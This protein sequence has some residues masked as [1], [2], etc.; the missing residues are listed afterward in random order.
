[1][2]L[3]LLTC[4]LLY[5]FFPLAEQ[6]ILGEWWYSLGPKEK[7]EYS[8]LANQV[9]EAHFKRHPDWKWC[10]RGG[11]NDKI[12]P[13]GLPLESSPGG[14][15][16]GI[17]LKEE[18][19]PPG[20]GNVVQSPSSSTDG[21]KSNVSKVAAKKVK[22]SSVSKD[23][24]SVGSAKSTDSNEG[25]ST[26]N[27]QDRVGGDQDRV[28][29]DQDSDS[30]FEEE[31]VIDL[32]RRDSM[33][34]DGEDSSQ[35]GTNCDHNTD[36]SNVEMN[37]LTSGHKSCLDT[38]SSTLGAKSSYVAREG[39]SIGGLSVTFNLQEPCSRSISSPGSSNQGGINSSKINSPKI[40]SSKINSSKINSSNSSGSSFITF[41]NMVRTPPPPACVT[42]SSHSPI[43]SLRSPV[44]MSQA[45][46]P[47][48]GTKSGIMK[49][50][51]HGYQDAERSGNQG[52]S[53]HQPQFYTTVMNLKSG[54]LS[55]RSPP[56]TI[57]PSVKIDAP[58]ESSSVTVPSSSG[59][60]FVLAPTPAQLGIIRNKKNQLPR[61]SSPTDLPTIV[62]SSTTSSQS[63]GQDGVPSQ[64]TSSRDDVPPPSVKEDT[65]TVK[66][67]EPAKDGPKEKAVAKEGSSDDKAVAKD[68]PK[69]GMDKVL[70]EVNF[71]Q[72]FA[73]LPEFKPENG[74]SAPSTPLPQLVPSPAAFVQ[75]YRKKQRV[76]KSSVTPSLSSVAPSSLSSVAPSL[77]SV[78]PNAQTLPQADRSSC[79]P[80]SAPNPTPITGNN[81]NEASNDSSNNSSAV[82]FFGPNFNI[83]EAI[84]S[85]TSESDSCPA[86]ASTP[87]TPRS[88]RTPGKDT[89][90]FDS[91]ST[92]QELLLILIINNTIININ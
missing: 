63:S 81:N 25:G 2:F 61:T 86:S 14:M 64:E 48:N 74:T 38:Q 59:P 23:S 28:G 15:V 36:S 72:R 77:S 30:D 8:S 84:A 34:V 9:K 67:D 65:S 7:Q 49:G 58:P 89:H 56:T 10:S 42:L 54:N 60:M 80:T 21:V 90:F 18:N 52:T 43:P 87:L 6:Q 45:S 31:M 13:D 33:D 50:S 27:P 32:K 40:N 53:H 92:H 35:D 79:V 55:V 91:I 39:T 24:S 29:G 57:V 11:S 3:I 12:G 41:R 70:E 82:T 51:N 47:G 17:G 88:P 37:D 26:Q 85:T 62:E 19:V 78:T 83:S 20:G 44:I 1:M 71:E 22:T 69:D 66:Y 68:G 4:S 76:D 5:V 16:A 75:S 46:S 73:R